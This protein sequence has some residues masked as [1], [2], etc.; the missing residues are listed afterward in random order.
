M[1]I[2]NINDEAEISDLLMEYFF[3]ET[4]DNLEE[5]K[6]DYVSDVDVINSRNDKIELICTLDMS[7]VSDDD[8]CFSF[9]TQVALNLDGDNIDN[10]EYKVDISILYN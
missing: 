2:T 5:F 7:H 6:L 1:R 10:V 3:E 4:I 8:I 9:P